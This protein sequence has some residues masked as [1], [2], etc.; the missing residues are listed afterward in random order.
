MKNLFKKTMTL[1][2]VGASVLLSS[3]ILKEAI[4]RVDEVLLKSFQP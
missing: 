4:F 1:L 2:L 3:L